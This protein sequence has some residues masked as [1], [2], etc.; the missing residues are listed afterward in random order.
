M[1]REHYSGVKNRATAIV[2]KQDP[3]YTGVAQYPYGSSV[4]LWFID[5]DQADADRLVKEYKVDSSKIIDPNFID[6]GRPSPE[7]IEDN[8]DWSW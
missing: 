2:Y 1:G 7:E 3:D 4:S 8:E 6:D 5:A